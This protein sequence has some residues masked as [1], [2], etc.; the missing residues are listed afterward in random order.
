MPDFY[1]LKSSHLEKRIHLD[2]AVTWSFFSKSEGN[3]SIGT[4]VT[5]SQRQALLETL[6]PIPEGRWIRLRM[7]VDRSFELLVVG[8]VART[9]YQQGSPSA[10][11]EIDLTHEVNPVVLALL[12]LRQKVLSRYQK[13]QARKSPSLTPA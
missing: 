6:A 4:L 12:E 10:F 9:T 11:Q 2:T 13:E 5:L 8:R 1:G 7:T 3:P